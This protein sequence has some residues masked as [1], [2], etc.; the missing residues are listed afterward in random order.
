MLAQDLSWMS[1]SSATASVLLSPQ[2]PAHRFYFSYMETTYPGKPREEGRRDGPKRTL[3]LY[4]VGVKM[5]LLKLGPHTS[6]VNAVVSAVPGK[7][8]KDLKHQ[9]LIRSF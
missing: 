6:V 2:D 9:V 7:V 1:C 8:K 5:E 3:W 4:E